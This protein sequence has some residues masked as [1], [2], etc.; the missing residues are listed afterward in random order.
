VVSAGVGFLRKV[1]DAVVG[2]GFHPLVLIDPADERVCTT[3]GDSSC[4]RRSR[5]ACP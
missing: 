3:V 1:R 2:H 4:R 5:L